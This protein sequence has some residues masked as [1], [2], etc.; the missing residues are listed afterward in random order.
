KREEQ[1]WLHMDYGPVI[2]ASVTVEEPEDPRADKAPGDN[3]SYRS[4]AV[5]LAAGHR[6][7]MIFDTELLR[8][9]A[10]WNGP[11]YVL[12]GTVYDWKHGPHPHLDGAPVFETPVAPGWAYGGSFADPRDEG[13]G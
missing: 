11:Q 4:H 12:T 3:V 7:G 1:P 13:H 8:M 9:S 6:A 2:S 5:M 10:G